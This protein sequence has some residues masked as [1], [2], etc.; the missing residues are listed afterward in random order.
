MRVMA[1]RAFSCH[2]K[3]WSCEPSGMQHRIGRDGQPQVHDLKRS[4]RILKEA[5]YQG[6]LCVEYGASE[7]E[8]E[9]TRDAMQYVRELVASL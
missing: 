6:P 1:P 4:L 3:A 9:S 5:D 2:I 8:R 7:N